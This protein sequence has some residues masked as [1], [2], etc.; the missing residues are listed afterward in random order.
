MSSTQFTTDI[1]DAL[2]QR[3]QQMPAPYVRTV[4]EWGNEIVDPVFDTVFLKPMCD[5]SPHK[6]QDHGGYLTSRIDGKYKIRVRVPEH[7]GTDL[8]RQV[9][10][11][12]AEHFRP[13]G[14]PV[15]Y[16]FDD[17]TTKQAVHIQR[18]PYS[19]G[20]LKEIDGLLEGTVIVEFF[21]TPQRNLT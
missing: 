4:I 14:V 19:E 5:M 9:Q 1:E 8:W 12:I 13:D 11:V 7:Q 6:L 20:E 10:D 15:A 3:L 2:H 18:E 21:A 17:L 16:S